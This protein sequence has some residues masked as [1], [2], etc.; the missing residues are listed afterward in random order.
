MTKQPQVRSAE[1]ALRLADW[2]LDNVQHINHAEAA[3]ELRRLHEVNQE[4]LEAY[5]KMYNAAAGYSNYC[6]DSAS[7]RRCERDFEKADAIF[8]AA[9]AK[10]EQP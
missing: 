6:E 3:A 8:R 7:V 4:L 10:G 1:E 9:I 2:L 5:R